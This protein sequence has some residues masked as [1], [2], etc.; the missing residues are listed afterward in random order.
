MSLFL[1][2]ARAYFALGWGRRSHARWARNAGYRRDVYAGVEW[3]WLEEVSLLIILERLVDHWA[4]LCLASVLFLLL[5]LM[6]LFLLN[7]KFLKNPIRMYG[8]SF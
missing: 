5:L 6:L 1:R 7:T 2:W 4:D 3:A 8:W